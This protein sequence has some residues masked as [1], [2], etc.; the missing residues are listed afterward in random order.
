MF[1]NC[2]LSDGLPICLDR[3]R[4]LIRQRKTLEK[5]RLADV[6]C[7]LAGF[8][9]MARNLLARNLHF[10]SSESNHNIL[11]LSMF[12]CGETYIAHPIGA[13]TREIEFPSTQIYKFGPKADTRRRSPK[14]DW[15]HSV[16]YLPL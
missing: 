4:C 3:T 9:I 10:W 13:R 7:T 15:S 11:E 8:N 2:P 1:K 5:A 12:C 14:K 16:I 6:T